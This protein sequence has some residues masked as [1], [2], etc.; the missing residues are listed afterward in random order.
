MDNLHY[1]SNK[2]R[3]SR[4]GSSWDW[5]NAWADDGF[6]LSSLAI[7]C[8]QDGVVCYAKDHRSVSQ[9]LS[10]VLWWLTYKNSAMR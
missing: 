5:V 6:N 4:E 3:S 9:Y 10:W 8:K 7:S 1:T 2:Q